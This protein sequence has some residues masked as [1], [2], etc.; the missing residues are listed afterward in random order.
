MNTLPN[1]HRKFEAASD[2]A[3]DV[4]ISMG[5]T[6]AARAADAGAYADADADVIW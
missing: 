6:G 1:L 5:G 2:L 4:G 3:A